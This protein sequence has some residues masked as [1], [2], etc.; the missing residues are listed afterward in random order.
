[1]AEREVTIHTVPGKDFEM[2]RLPAVYILTPENDTFP[3]R[4]SRRGRLALDLFS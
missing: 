4:I 3:Y 2:D 1:M